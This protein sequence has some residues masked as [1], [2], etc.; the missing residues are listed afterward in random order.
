MIYLH[1]PNE[2]SVFGKHDGL[3][4]I[5]SNLWK[6][7]FCNNTYSPHKIQKIIQDAN[8]IV[9][10]PKLNNENKISQVIKQTPLSHKEEPTKQKVHEMEYINYFNSLINIFRTKKLE[11]K[12]FESDL[13]KKFPNYHGK[14]IRAEEI[15]KV[16]NKYGKEVTT[17]YDYYIMVEVGYHSQ[18]MKELE[19]IT[20]YQ[21]DNTLEAPGYRD[22]ISNMNGTFHLPRD[23]TG[24]I[25]SNCVEDYDE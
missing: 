24:R 15:N 12:I 23:Y 14:K 6:C 16:L 7:K 2:K 18:R 11:E 13:Q 1:C 9:I 25:S 5:K 17:L 20:F 8:K 21:Y 10:T 3:Y 22:D 4:Q 19:K